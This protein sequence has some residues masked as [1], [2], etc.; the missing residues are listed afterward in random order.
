MGVNVLHAVLRTQRGLN[1][2]GHLVSIRER[3]V[4]V[5]LEMHRHA[6][7]PV[8]AVDGDVVHVANERLGER[9]G[10]GAVAQAEA[11]AARLE[12]HSDLAIGKR[13]AHR[14]FDRF[15]DLLPL[16]GRL[17]GWDPDDRVGEVVAARLSNAQPPELDSVTQ[18]GDRLVCAR[19]RFGW[20]GVHQHARVLEDQASRRGEDQH[21]DDQRGDRVALMKAGADGDQAHEHGQ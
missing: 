7:T 6:D 10:Q 19:V 9:G 13:P 15:A 18:I 12:V 1:T 4:G 16:D 5:H 20:R 21:G 11:F 17:S 2:L 8:M 14:R 3:D